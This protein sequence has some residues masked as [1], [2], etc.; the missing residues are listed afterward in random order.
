MPYRNT[1]IAFLLPVLAIG[2]TGCGYSTADKYV[3]GCAVRYLLTDY[4]GAIADCD[5]AIKIDPRDGDAYY[6][7]G[8]A[9]EMDGDLN[10]ACSDWRQ[11]SSLGDKEA[12]DHVSDQC[13]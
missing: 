9:K 1:A 4:Q 5:K 2:S 6:N 11:A 7:R 8:I 10:G 12:A 13:Q 3:L